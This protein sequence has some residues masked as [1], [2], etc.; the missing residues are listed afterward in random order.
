MQ[1]RVGHW[2]QLAFAGGVVIK[3]DQHARSFG[4]C[5]DR[6][7]CRDGQRARNFGEAQFEQNGNANGKSHREKD[8]SSIKVRHAR[9]LCSQSA[10]SVVLVCS[11]GFLAR[12]LKVVGADWSSMMIAAGLC[13]PCVLND[14]LLNA[15]VEVRAMHQRVD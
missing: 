11:H 9:E 8:P 1:H 5:F 15:A 12:S 3:R 4:H 14:A 7:E 10:R 13:A 2:L 6:V